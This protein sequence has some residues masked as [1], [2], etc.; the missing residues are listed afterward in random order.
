MS[1]PKELRRNAQDCLTRA[2]AATDAHG[3]FLL[4]NMAKAW[5]GVS[6]QVEQLQAKRGTAARNSETATTEILTTILTT[7]A[8]PQEA[9]CPVPNEH[10]RVP[11]RGRKFQPLRCAS[12]SE[13]GV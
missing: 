8:E 1:D 4:L 7:R 3:E 9:Q 12:A 10:K 2:R 13:V 6:Q 5:L 11:R